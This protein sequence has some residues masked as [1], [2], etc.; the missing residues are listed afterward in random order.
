MTIQQLRAKLEDI[1][2]KGY[3]GA[4]SDAA[5]EEIVDAWTAMQLQLDQLTGLP[6]DAPAG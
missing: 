3:Y 1:E 5:I 6:D 2:A 4:E